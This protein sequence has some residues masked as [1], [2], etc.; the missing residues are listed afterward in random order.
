MGGNRTILLNAVWAMLDH[1]APGYSRVLKL[2]RWWV[3]FNGFTYRDLPLGKHGARKNPEVEAGKVRGM[4]RHL[5]IV[6]CCQRR[7]PDIW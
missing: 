4:A 1:C 6:D 5:Q 2:H 3:S 7:L